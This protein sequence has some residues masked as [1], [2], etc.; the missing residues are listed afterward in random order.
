MDLTVERAALARTL[1]AA[2][3]AVEKRNTIPILGNILLVA[4]A[5]RLS[6]RATDL[7]IEIHAHVPADVAKPG[8]CTVDAMRLT[9][10]ARKVAG[11]TVSMVLDGANLTVKS[12]R[13]G[14]VLPTLPAED[15][16]SLPDADYAAMFDVDLD[17]LVKPVKFAMSTEE[18]RY[19]LNGTYLHVEDGRL[20]V[21]ATD[22]HRLALNLGQAV[23]T[24]DGVIVPRKT[25]EILPTGAVNVSVSDARIRIANDDMVILSKLVDGSFPDY[26]RVIPRSNDKTLT[27]DREA[28]RSGADRVATV[29]SD[30][31]RAV[32]VG[33]SA[34]QVTLSVTADAGQASEDI[35]AAYADDA[36][37]IGFNAKYLVDILG[38]L[39]GAEV[40]VRLADSGCPALFTG[41]GDLVCVG[42]P[43]RI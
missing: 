12:G 15:F 8:R 38:A 23:D 6:V 18:T 43:M 24:F 14:F 1:A 42:M 37:E 13:S 31:V 30:R 25:V 7:D 16:P 5:D 33:L 20:A 29:V 11:T 9:D 40:T 2:G 21:V 39:S 32:R 10:I 36:M 26:R 41:D 3:K 27:V 34:D 28:L 19:Y 17:A 4:E 35:P 22:G